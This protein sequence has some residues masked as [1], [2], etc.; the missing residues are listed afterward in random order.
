[1][2]DEKIIDLYFKRDEKAIEETR[3]KYLP[4]LAKISLAVLGDAGEAEECVNDAYFR[5]WQS[6]PPTRPESLS[7]YLA[8]VVRRI[9]ISRLRIRT[10]GK[11]NGAEYDLSLEELGECVPSGPGAAS[12]VEDEVDREELGRVI[13]RYL[14]TLDPVERRVFT[15]RYFYLDPVR[16][17]AASSGLTP[18][19][20]RGM[21]ERS[22][23]G[24]RRFLEK[25]GYGRS[26][27]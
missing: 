10:A 14:L 5:A 2:E 19:R 8:A 6:I 7:A 25:E 18:G 22:R 20:V 4:Y 26:R 13:S 21:L 16:A 9:S 3:R 17:V 12:P 23:E 15:A 24:L 27:T 11:R 1:M